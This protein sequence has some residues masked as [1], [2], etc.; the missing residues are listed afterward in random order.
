M[1]PRQVSAL[2]EIEGRDKKIRKADLLDLHWMAAHI[3]QKELRKRL[4]EM[5]RAL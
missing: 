3:D 1:S 2:T 5:K 4:R